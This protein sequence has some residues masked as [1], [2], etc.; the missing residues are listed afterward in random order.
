MN[1]IK[2][3][4]LEA[5]IDG[6]IIDAACL[7]TS[8][9]VVHGSHEVPAAEAKDL[10]EMGQL[11]V[12]PTQ[13]SRTV[14]FVHSINRYLPFKGYKDRSF[15]WLDDLNSDQESRYSGANTA[16][17]STDMESCYTWI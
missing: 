13:D 16:S 7:L 5:D 9:E 17:L 14:R 4:C 8:P 11:P 10:A 1:P 6:S 3:T 12:E 2:A 15:S